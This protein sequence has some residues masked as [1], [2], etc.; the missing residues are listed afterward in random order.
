MLK[1]NMAVQVWCRLLL[2]ASLTLA[3]N[4]QSIPTRGANTN[5]KSG[6]G[7]NLRCSSSVPSPH[8]E[9]RKKVSD[10]R[11]IEV[12][13]SA[14][15][16]ADAPASVEVPAAEVEVVECSICNIEFDPFMIYEA[17][18][19]E[20]GELVCE[21]ENMKICKACMAQVGEKFHKE[22]FRV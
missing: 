3:L 18:T 5:P 2:S 6:V 15:G 9:S 22:N 13:C 17:P 16:S 10:D 8:T 1:T 21:H 4:L 19:D 12:S 7:P 11:Q 14:K 20:N